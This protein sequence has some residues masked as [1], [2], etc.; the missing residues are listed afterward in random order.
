MNR[1]AVVKALQTILPRSPHF[2][3]LFRRATRFGLSTGVEG[4][5][6][7]LDFARGSVDFEYVGEPTP[8]RA[9]LWL[10]V[11]ERDLL[12][13]ASDAKPLPRPKI[14]RPAGS[15]A[16]P[17][18]ERLL[19]RVFTAPGTPTPVS[20]REDLVYPA[21]FGT[22]PAQQLWKAEDL[23]VQVLFYPEAVEGRHAY[24]TS[25]FSN[26]ELGPPATPPD[27]VPPSGFGYEMILFEEE[28]A[29]G[30]LAGQFVAWVRYVCR[31]REH[32]VRGNWLEYAEGGL[33]GTVLAGF[34]IVPPVTIP[35]T[36][37]VGTG[38]AQWSLLLG[39]TAEE[40]ALAKQTRVMDVAQKLL[41]AGY[42]DAV[43]VQRPSVV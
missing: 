13:F 11:R 41:E 40:L 9:P 4:L 27:D 21:L 17:E 1:D 26:P 14:V 42:R 36:F 5:A 20:D 7:D 43:P 23:P 24:V 22:R 33:P 19:L 30:P 2:P 37:P 15:D 16:P 38:Q 32:V 18:L 6:V 35:R 12:A 29:L 28:Q 31:S 10:E 39:A 8:D 25:G 34:L 3:L